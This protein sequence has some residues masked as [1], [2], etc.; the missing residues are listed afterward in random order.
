[1]L[2]TCAESVR[3]VATVGARRSVG[4]ATTAACA[5]ATSTAIH[6]VESGSPVA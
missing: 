6:P 1:M 2:F 5:T 4:A 3:K